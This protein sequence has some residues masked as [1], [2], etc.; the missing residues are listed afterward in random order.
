MLF[1]ASRGLPI[2]E[3]RP[4]SWLQRMRWRLHRVFQRV[5]REQ[6]EIQMAHQRGLEKGWQLASQLF[7]AAVSAKSKA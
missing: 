5:P 7:P 6:Y 4:I 2:K 3:P 1:R